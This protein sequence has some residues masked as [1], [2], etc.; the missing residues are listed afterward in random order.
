MSNPLIDPAEIGVVT[1]RFEW[2][3]DDEDLGPLGTYLTLFIVPHGEEAAAEL[4]AP[5]AAFIPGT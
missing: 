3:N 1:S 4:V 2:F 5:L